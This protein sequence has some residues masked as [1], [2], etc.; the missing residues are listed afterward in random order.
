MYSY[1]NQ[2]LDINEVVDKMDSSK[3]DNAI[4][5]VENTIQKNTELQ[6]KTNYK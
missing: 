2:N 4:T 6:S 5:Q 1:D 3:L